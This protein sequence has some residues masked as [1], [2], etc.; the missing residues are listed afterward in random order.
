[1]KQAKLVHIAVRSAEPRSLADFYKSAFG[2][3][4]VLSNRRAV[5]LW[6]GYLFL[7]INPPSANG[8][9]GLNHFGFVVDDVDSLRPVLNRAGASKI[10]ARPAGRSFTDWRVHDPEGNPIDLSSRGYDTIPEERLQ[11]QSDDQ[12]MNA[13]RRL[14]ILSQNPE[15]LARFYTQ[16]FGMEAVKTSAHK[17]ILTDGTMQLVL[18][19]LGSNPVSGLYCYGLAAND[20]A[21]ETLQRL[22]DSRLAAA[23]EADWVDE[24]KRQ[25]HFRDPEKNLVT[26]F[27]MN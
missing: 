1:M 21:D 24:G 16:A 11:K 7:A 23:W 8:P 14:V 19:N 2:L 26:L 20:S 25:V 15:Q 17:V 6:D 3:K 27:G 4:E 22:R 18:L 9:M 10:E 12:A 5:D 13:V